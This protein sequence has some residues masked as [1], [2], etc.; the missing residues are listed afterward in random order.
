MSFAYPGSDRQVLDK[1][2]LEFPAGT[3]TAIVGLNG[4][5]KTTLVKL[6]ARLYEPTGGRISVDGAD[7]GGFDARS[8]QRSLAMIYQDYIRYELDAATNIGLGAP[9]PHGRPGRDRA[10]VRMGW[11]HRGDRR[12]PRGLRTVL[13][14][15]YQ[16]GTDLSGGQWQRIALARALFA[17]GAG[18][19]VLVLDE[20]TAQ[21]DVRA[22]VAFFDRFLELTQGLTTMVISH[23]FSTVRRAQRIV[24]LEDGRITEQ[25]THE[26][27]I[28]MEGSYAKLFELQA[29]RFSAGEE[30]PADDE[31]LALADDTGAGPETDQCAVMRVLRAGR[32]LFSLGMKARPRPAGAGSGPHAR[33]LHG[34]A[35]GRPGAEEPHRQPART[36]GRPRPCLRAPRRAALIA[37]LMLSHFAHLD[38][39]E[40]AE[41]QQNRLRGELMY[42]VNGPPGID[43]L[44]RADFAD[45]IGLVRDGLFAS[46]RA[47]EAVLQLA[48]L[49]LQTAMTVGDSHRPQPV[50]RLPAAVRG[51]AGTAGTRGAVRRGVG[52]GSKPQNSSGSTSTSSNSRPVS[53]RCGNCACSVPSGPAGQAAEHLGRNDRGHVARPAEG[54]GLPR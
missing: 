9:E 29:R 20:P 32:Y 43:H 18:A 13:S 26:E 6:L 19:S 24:V 39:F 52:H 35:P 22:E 23:R 1:I 21:L 53:A 47:L 2:D 46:T 54:G 50:L 25:G 12:L 41:L 30:E 49:L 14:S 51:H 27:L 10:G 37:Q 48:G 40:V 36:A 16:G 44:D 34:R 31:D 11:R 5:G 28:T 45:N 4:A 7:L 15:R 8:W 38:Y 17:A 42:L 33:R 3:S